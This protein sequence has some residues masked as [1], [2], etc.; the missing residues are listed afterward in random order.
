MDPGPSCPWTSGTVSFRDWEF[1][2]GRGGTALGSPVPFSGYSFLIKTMWSY[3][4]PVLQAGDE[5]LKRKTVCPNK[6]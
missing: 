1:A 5:I 3:P 6:D 4:W 2:D